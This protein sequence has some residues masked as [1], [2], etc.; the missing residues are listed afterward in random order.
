[1]REGRA[2]WELVT[3]K[4]GHQSDLEGLE[5]LVERF[6]GAFPTDRVAQEHREKIKHLVASHAPSCK[7]HTLTDLA[8]DAVLA[9][10]GSQQHDACQTRKGSR[11]QMFLTKS[12]G[13]KKGEKL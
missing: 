9:K 12:Q 11:G 6:Q 10:M 2:S 8:Q 7:A 4:Q 5:P 1:T 13:C 3:F